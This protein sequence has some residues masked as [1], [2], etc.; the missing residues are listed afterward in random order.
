MEI[1][2]DEVGVTRFHGR[3]RAIGVLGSADHAISRIVF[4]EIFKRRNEL[5]IVVDDQDLEHP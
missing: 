1:E 3:N 2:K 4:D 5:D